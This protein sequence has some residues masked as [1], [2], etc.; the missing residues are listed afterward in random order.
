MEKTFEESFAEKANLIYEFD[1][2]SP[3]FVRKA[4][5]E[6]ESQNLES[7][8]S[9]LH[10]GIQIYPDYPVAYILLGKALALQG[11]YDEAQAAY[12]T[13]CGLIDSP[14]SLNYYL[15]QVEEVKKLRSPFS[16]KKRSTFVEEPLDLSIRIPEARI[17]GSFE[18][19]LPHLA[20]RLSKAKINIP[21][22]NQEHIPLVSAHETIASPPIV[23]ET[24]AR[25]Y[26][27]QGNM[28][29]AIHI[30]ELLMERSPEKTVEYQRAIADL[31]SRL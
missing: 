15:A 20:E 1:S 26:I 9:I 6:I 5:R 22:E 13:G 12:S 27:S 4:E 7:A 16:I 30:Y 23:S 24:L 3:L 19:T 29:E 28:T 10:N 18:D 17:S 11:K 2:R 14:D 31:Q 21:D 25:I 8:I